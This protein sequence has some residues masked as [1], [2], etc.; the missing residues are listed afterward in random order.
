MKKNVGS[1]DKIVR[2]VLG[3]AIGA[4]GYYYQSW[5]GL[6]GIIPVATALINFCPVYT[7]FKLSTAE[8]PKE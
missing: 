8:K 7:L 2:I 4:A 5:L 6:I 3:L 1:V